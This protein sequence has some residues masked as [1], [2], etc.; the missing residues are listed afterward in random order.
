MLRNIL[1]DFYQFYYYF[2]FI[3]YKKIGYTDDYGYPIIATF[4]MSIPQCINVFT[5]FANSTMLVSDFQIAYYVVNIFIL[6]MNSYY[7]NGT[8]RKKIIE[9]KLNHLPKFTKL[10]YTF[11]I[12]IYLIFTIY[13][14]RNVLIINDHI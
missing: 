9:S 7:F 1:I 10:I 13:Y 3:T 14:L 6:L 8:R 5:I 12:I 4:L 11:F 2:F